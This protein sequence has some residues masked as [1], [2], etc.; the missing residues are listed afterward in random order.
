[1]TNPD[2]FAPPVWRSPV[3]R[4]PEGMIMLVQLARLIGRVIWFIFTHPATDA[5]VA[6]VV[7]D[8]VNLGW[9]GVLGL[10]LL[11][12]AVLV[13]LRL[14]WPVWFS[15][16]V[17][18]P[19]RDRWRWWCYRRRWHAA[20]TLAGLAPL[21]RGRVLVPVLA[22]VR[23]ASA[24]D[25]VTVGLVTGQSPADF[26]GRT[27]NLAHAF[28]AGLCR[29]RDAGPG[30]VVLELVRADTLADPIPAFPLPLRHGEDEPIVDLNAILHALYDRAR[31]DLRLDYSQPPVP[32]LAE[33]DAAWSRGR[34]G[35]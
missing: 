24:V 5:A 1:M 20:M 32:P 29:V 33:A 35:S 15:R 18:C 3:Y 14:L 10:A 22:G 17:A 19:A 27:E 8:W 34:I 11:V 30:M 31:F 9:P 16:F 6:L 13:A 21:Y 7:F 23:A 26:A 25:L 28:G 2:P 4:T 12:A